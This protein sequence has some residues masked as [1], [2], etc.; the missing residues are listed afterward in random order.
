MATAR[1]QQRGGAVTGIHVWLIAFVGLWLISTV[2]LVWLYTGQ[3]GLVKK[4]DDLRL[5]NDGLRDDQRD[6][7]GA[8]DELAKLTTGSPEDDVATVQ[9]KVGELLARIQ[10]DGAVP[11]PSAFD[12]PSAG[13]LTAMTALYEGFI[14]EH[15]LRLAAQ[16][17]AADQTAEVERL[18]TEKIEREQA[19]DAKQDELVAQ[20][21]AL[22]DDRT[23]YRGERNAEVDQF[24]Q[25]LEDLRQQFTRDI[26]EQRNENSRLTQ[27]LAETKSRHA[28]LQAKLGE[29]QIQPEPLLT[30]R[31]GD[32]QVLM[33]K[34]GEDVVYIN[35]GRQDKVTR[36]MQFAVYSG[37]VGI[38]AD[39]SSKARIEIARIFES[40]SEC[41]V[42]ETS[43]N[44]VILEG[45]IINNPIYDRARSL[46]FAVTG[47]F[48]FDGDGRDDPDGADKIKALIREW[49]GQVA[50]AVT[51]RVDFV[52]V[53]NP[54]RRPT[55]M[56]DASPEAQERDA[57]T[58]RLF[59]A[60]NRTVET[61][62]ALSVP[63][64][65]QGKLLYF[66]GYA[67]RQGG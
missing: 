1:G 52:V 62:Q 49:G 53:G 25:R 12:D 26:Q 32:G 54:P 37:G 18:T 13:A 55:T 57:L 34:P 20:I 39:G 3:S 21:Q 67:A 2:L 43:G 6:Q 51:A 11:D 9:T 10:D 8:R 5:D 28:D 44:E 48:D 31:A 14:G 66:L 17:K 15:E 41:V 40:A 24:E 58:R 27:E 46:T 4:A 7:Q 56:G 47:T 38:P 36:G 22:E 35:L 63:I 42:R 16:Q 61:A 59:E 65:P 45:D 19:F 64:L 50:D 29:L 33:A 23:R 30:A 60:H